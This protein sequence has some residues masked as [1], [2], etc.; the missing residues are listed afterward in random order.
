M[1]YHGL[2]PTHGCCGTLIEARN[3]QPG[4]VIPHIVLVCSAGCGREE[5]L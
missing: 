2:C 4:D 1:A 3:E 5:D